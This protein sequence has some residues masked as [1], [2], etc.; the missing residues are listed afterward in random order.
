M[1]YLLRNSWLPFSFTFVKEKLPKGPLGCFFSLMGDGS[2]KRDFRQESLSLLVC[3]FCSHRTQ[4]QKSS[5]ELKMQDWTR[6]WPS[7]WKK[8]PLVV[9][10]NMCS[11]W[12]SACKILELSSISRH[13][14]IYLDPGTSLV[15]L[16][17][18]V[19]T[20]FKKFSNTRKELEK[21][22]FI[23]VFFKRLKAT[24]PKRRF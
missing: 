23:V 22:F 4:T 7:I 21:S 5:I 15:R 18:S 8:N 10:Q 24:I 1:S 9:E 13:Q 17:F 11:T 3:I 14:L 6:C 19:E 12:R 20:I 16:H 2:K